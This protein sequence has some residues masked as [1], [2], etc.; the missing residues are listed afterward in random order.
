[1]AND[2]IAAAGR[3]LAEAWRDARTIDAYP[4]DLAP[5]DLD[6]A[7]AI[8]EEMARE[9]GEDV[10]GWK[11]AGRPGPLIGRI[12]KST[13]YSDPAELPVARFPK[14]YLE[15]EI[16]F[17]LT[18]DLPP[19]EQAYGE[20]E[21]AGSAALAL[22]V[23]FVGSRHSNG[24]LIPDNDA[25]LHTIVADNAV[26]A[27]LVA[28]PVIEDWRGLSLLDI[29]VE[30]RIDGGPPMPTIPR[31]ERTEPLDVLVWLANELSD[32]GIGLQAG[33]I[34]TPGSATR[35]QLLP[36]GSTALAVFG[37]LGQI[38]VTLA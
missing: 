7:I 36:A 8:R 14:P 29:A 35:P 23:E 18:S 22:N 6:Q 13:L 9:I 38:S 15:C 34:V 5:S 37:E 19:R 25:D 32:L 12:F 17:R 28:G 4:A 33:Q 2:K 24:K 30:L 31:E 20:E 1:M 21:V 10:V 27:G 16:G 3:L 11:V 26:Q